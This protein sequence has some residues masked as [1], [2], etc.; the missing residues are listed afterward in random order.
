M[1]ATVIAITKDLPD[2]EGDKA[3]NIETFA[4]RMGVK[5]VSL[6]GEQRRR[7]YPCKSFGIIQPSVSACHCSVLTSMEVHAIFDCAY[8]S[9]ILHLSP[10]C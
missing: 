9:N 1:F 4:T 10:R 3:N 7:L 5:N 8:G 2:I 6:L